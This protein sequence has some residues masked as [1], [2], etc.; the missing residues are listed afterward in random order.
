MLQNASGQSTASSFPLKE[1]ILATA[2][3]EL[4]PR[5]ALFEA[6]AQFKSPHQ[7]RAP[8]SDDVVEARRDFL[9]SFAYL[10]DVK[11][12]GATV[13]AAGLQKLPQSNILWLAANEGIRSDV[14]R[15]ADEIL[16]KLKQSDPNTETIT[17]NT[18][19]RPAVAQCRSRIIDYTRRMQNLAK[20][21]RKELSK[22][23]ENDTGIL[24]CFLA[25]RPMLT[26]EVAL[27]RRNLTKLCE[28]QPKTMPVDVVDFCYGMRGR[29]VDEIKR[30][31]EQA[32]NNFGELA[33]YIGRLGAT[34]SSVHTVVKG[35]LKD[36]ALRQISCIRTVDAPDIRTVT[37]DQ[38]TMSPYEILRGI[39]QDAGSQIQLENRAALHALVELDLPSGNGEVRRILASRRTVVTRVHA[40]LQIADTFSRD[41]L[42]FVDGDKYIGCSKPACYF[43]F[44]WLVSHKHG[45]IPPATHSKIIPSCRGPDNDINESGAAVL[46]YIYAKVCTQVGQDTVD[47]LLKTGPDHSHARHQYQSTEG[48]SCAY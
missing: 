13:T 37:L 39:C 24:L 12:G 4:Y 34:R 46:K 29:D 21:C 44:H 23:R 3:K 9:D 35:V 42:K 33:H 25:K 16:L 48:S 18:I 28:L 1:H 47:F 8:C 41:R 36:P 38:C 10:G 20:L 2:S 7:R 17:Q 45:F 40:E 14:V 43:C 31:S 27:L 5:L 22:E 15:Y 32:R 19:F 11:K 30:R 6:L 26:L